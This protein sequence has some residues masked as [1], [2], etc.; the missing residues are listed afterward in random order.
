MDPW[1]Y[2]HVD[3][4]IVVR[5]SLTTCDRDDRTGIKISV[6]LASSLINDCYLTNKKKTLH[7]MKTFHHGLTSL[8]FIFSFHFASADPAVLD[9]SREYFFPYHNLQTGIFVIK[10]GF[11]FPRTK[12]IAKVQLFKTSQYTSW[13]LENL[14]PTLNPVCEYSAT[15]PSQNTSY[16]FGKRLSWVN[17]IHLPFFSQF[18]QLFQLFYRIFVPIRSTNSAIFVRWPQLKIIKLSFYYRIFVEPRRA[19]IVQKSFI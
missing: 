19:T 2:L 12:N 9:D 15:M 6:L 11:P 13:N 7:K 4:S 18:I 3:N 14:W 8:L 16:T 10:A 1:Y 5:R 17:Y